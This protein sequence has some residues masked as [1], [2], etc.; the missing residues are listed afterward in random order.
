MEIRDDD[1]QFLIAN[2]PKLRLL[3]FDSCDLSNV[4]D[5]GL[6]GLKEDG[7]TYVRVNKDF[8]LQ[9]Q[10]FRG[11]PLSQLKRKFT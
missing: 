5:F 10:H 6:T 7:M 2:S 11:S 8:E 9:P 1:L 3:H 4:T